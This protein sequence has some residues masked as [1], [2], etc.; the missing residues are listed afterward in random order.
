MSNVIDARI[1]FLG[2]AV[3]DELERFVKNDQKYH[4]YYLLLE[5]DGE[6]YLELRLRDT[7]N[8]HDIVL[9]KAKICVY[10]ERM[11][12]GSPLFNV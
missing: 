8:N 11:Q 4:P 9:D 12:N 10:H 5:E 1:E 7:T 2:K 3:L 6:D